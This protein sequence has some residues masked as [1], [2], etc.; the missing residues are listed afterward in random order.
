ME[1]YI[2][3]D[4]KI[5]QYLLGSLPKEET[6]RLDELSV[7][8]DEY[9]KRVTVVENNL[10][11]SYVRGELSGEELE[12]FNAHYLASPKR[13]EKTAKA[14]Q[15]FSERAAGTGKG[16]MP[17]QTQILS[18][19][20][21]SIPNSSILPGNFTFPRLVFAVAV[22]GLAGICWLLFELSSL[23]SQVDQAQ[24]DR[25]AQ[26][27]RN[28]ALEQRDKKLEGELER[29][30][31]ANSASEKELERIR[32]EKDRLER[33]MESERRIAK[34]QPPALPTN[35]NIASFKL[36]APSRA[37]GQATTITLPPRT[38]YIA[39]QLELEPDYYPAYNAILQTQPGRKPTGW[40]RERLRSRELGRSKVID[41]LIPANR[42]RGSQEY[43][44]SLSGITG[45]GIAECVRGYPFW[46]VKK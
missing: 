46:V 19:S 37:A 34:S 14:F 10:V 21:N 42:L 6:E 1:K 25:N 15:T 9:A 38:D 33:Q 7:I 27:E 23:R 20:D 17:K 43:L 5:I 24:I 18:I 26:I 29:Q 12:R 45:G 22:L 41:V 11:E 36:I 44:M 13:R 28:D 32:K 3:N 2:Y 4:K 30:R 39:L 31:S 16:A 40:K 8:D 35:L